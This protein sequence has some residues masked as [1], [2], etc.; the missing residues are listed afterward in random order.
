MVIE[1]QALVGLM[2]LRGLYG[3]NHHGI[4]LLFTN[5]IGPNV[6]GATMSQQQMK[7]L[8]AHITFD[9]RADRAEL[10]PTDRFAAARNIFEA[11]NRNCS[12]FV[13]PSEFLA[14]DETLYPMRHQIAFRQYNP[15][16][17]HQYGMLIKSLND[18]RFPFTYKAAPYAGKPEQGDGLYYISATED[19][20]KY[21]VNETEKDTSLQGRN[22]STERLYT[23]IPLAN[24]LLDRNITT[25]G[26]LTTNRIGLPNELK[27]T[28]CREECSVTCHVESEDKNMSCRVQRQEHVMSSQKTRTCHVESEDKNMSCRV[29]RQEHVMSSQK[30]RTCHVESEDKNMYLTT[31]AVKTKSTGRK[32]V[33]MLSTMQ[34]MGGITKDDKKFKP[35][36]FKLSITSLKKKIVNQGRFSLSKILIQCMWK[37]YFKMAPLSRFK[38]HGLLKYC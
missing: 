33:F 28:R 21:L 19:Y 17:P 5:S 10:W 18:S 8:L 6:F 24:W 20:V 4:E 1:I 32:N 38:L 37:I 7:F 9:E 29:Q 25:V 14:I 36:I 34:P 35:A 23:S 31:Y 13:I 12:K 2:H 15:N 16:K 30:T 11:F 22:I 26:T 27:D 3:L